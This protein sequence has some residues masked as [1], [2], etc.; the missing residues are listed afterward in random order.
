VLKIK[1]GNSRSYI[2]F[3]DLAGSERNS[4]FSAEEHEAIKESIEINK[5]LF[6][7]KKVINVLSS[8][9]KSSSK[10]YVP[11]RDS[12]LTTLL[13]QS[14]SGRSKCLIIACANVLGKFR[15][16]TLSTLTYVSKA[17]CIVKKA[18]KIS[19]GKQRLINEQKKQI[20]DLTEQLQ[21]AHS[22]IDHF[23]ADWLY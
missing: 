2:N 3:V 11:F 19:D 17:G 15:E 8:N 13:K 10:D 22:Q 14:L 7:L 16:E 23:R 20:R 9:S 21:K 5:S 6:T 1:H 4:Y 12:K 18:V